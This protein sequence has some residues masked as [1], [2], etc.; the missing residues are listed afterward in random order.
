MLSVLT[1]C[2]IILSF[3]MPSFIMINFIMLRV[4][5]AVLFILGAR[6]KTIMLDVIMLSFPVLSAIFLQ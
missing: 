2:G 1:G 3:I 4:I 6:I 5:Y